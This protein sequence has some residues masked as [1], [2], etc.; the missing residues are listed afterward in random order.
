MGVSK[1][2]GTPKKD[3]LNWK[4]L[5][6]WMIWGKNPLFSE[7]SISYQE[8]KHDHPTAS[9]AFSRNSHHS[10][11]PGRPFWTHKAWLNSKRY[12][13]LFEK[14][15]SRRSRSICSIESWLVNEGIRLKMVYEI[16]PKYTYFR[17]LVSHTKKKQTPILSI[18][19]WLLKVPGSLFSRIIS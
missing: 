9:R 14:S 3:G 16:I 12:F 8:D 10:D 15:N 7:T 17:K 4:T 19:S 18:E 13:Y 11:R 5:L 2:R 1:N 6:K